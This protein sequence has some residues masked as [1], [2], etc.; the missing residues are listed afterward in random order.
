MRLVTY[1]ASIESEGRLG[2]L[3]DDLVIDVAILGAR[4]NVPMPSRMLDFI[5]LGPVALT[6]LKALLEEAKGRWP[7]GGA[8]PLT[9]IT[10]LAPIPRPRKNIFGIGIIVKK[11]FIFLHS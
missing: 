10:L 7:V 4:A 9:N 1:R 5:D 8:L 11:T 2:V 3:V 6:E